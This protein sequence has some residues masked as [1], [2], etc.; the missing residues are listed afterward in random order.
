MRDAH[1]ED[2]DGRE[3]IERPAPLKLACTSMYGILAVVFDDLMRGEFH[4]VPAGPGIEE[5]PSWRGQVHLP[6]P[7]AAVLLDRSGRLT[8]A[9]RLLADF[10][11]PEPV[12]TAQRLTGEL[13]DWTLMLAHVPARGETARAHALLHSV[14]APQQPRLCRLLRDSTAHRLTP[15]RSLEDDLPV[16]DRD[17]YTATTAPAHQEAVRAAAQRSWQGSRDL[18]GAAAQRWGIGLPVQPHQEIGAFPSRG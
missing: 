8:A 15:S 2:F 18:A 16:S 5:V 3:F 12:T 10:R 14:I 9:A 6:D 13:A 4:V 1:A 7:G 17:R 11:P